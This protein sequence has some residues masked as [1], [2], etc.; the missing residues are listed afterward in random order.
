VDQKGHVEIIAVFPEEPVSL[1]NFQDLSGCG[2]ST[3]G[4]CGEEMLPAQPVPTSVAIGPDG[5]YYVGEL[6]GFP[7]P[8]GESN[9]WKISP[10]AMAAQCG[11]SPD[12]VKLFDGGFT[13]IIDM[14]FGDDGMLYVA[15]MDVRSW[16]AVEGGLGEGGR[17]QRCDPQ[18][19]DCDVIAEDIFMLTSIVFDKEG[20]LWA[21]QNSLIPGEAE[22]VQV[23]Y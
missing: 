17:I 20:R 15:E 22:V 6:K 9:I 16:L 4:L 14:A 13:S 1:A 8:T 21:T 11:S 10:A 3:E 18:T 2:D 12:C 7:A 23:S 5:Y 19:L